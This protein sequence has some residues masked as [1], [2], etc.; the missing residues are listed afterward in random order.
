MVMAIQSL[1]AKP[2]AGKNAEEFFIH[3]NIPTFL[4]SN[5]YANDSLSWITSKEADVLLLIGGYGIIKEPLLSLCPQGVF[6]YHHGDMRKY[7]GQPPALWELYNNE[8]EMGVTVQKLHAGLDSGNPIVEKRFPIQRG[9]TLHS[10][11]KRI[12]DG[13][14]QMMF[15]AIETASKP[16]F[17]YQSLEKLGTIFTHPNLRQ[18]LLLQVKILWRQITR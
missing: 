15:Q 7:R 5:P 8:A 1:F 17:C 13:S 11:V 3:H 4:A 16:G 18:W 9:D 2:S 6:S 10:V 14:P 12:Y